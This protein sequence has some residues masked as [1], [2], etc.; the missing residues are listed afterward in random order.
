MSQNAVVKLK[1][2]FLSGYKIYGWFS[3]GGKR[4]LK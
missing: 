3:T 4:L 1:K 2:F